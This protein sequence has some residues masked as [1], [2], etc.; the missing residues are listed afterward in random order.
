MSKP[1]LTVWRRYDLWE[2][3]R[4]WGLTA[5]NWVHFPYA[6]DPRELPDF[7][8]WEDC[9]L[10]TRKWV[11]TASTLILDFKPPEWHKSNFYCLQTSLVIEQIRLPASARDTGSIPDLRRFYILRI[12]K[13]LSHKYWACT[14]YPANCKHWSPST[15]GAPA[16][17]REKLLRWEARAL[18]LENR[19]RLLL[20]EKTSHS[21]KDPAHSKTN[22]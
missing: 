1:E 3:I 11:L 7:C 21:S 14:L 9:P 8:W 22:K 12:V 16:L 17:Q 2:V 6:R 5:H 18:Q 19:P 10:W 4:S 15:P 13:P 20:L